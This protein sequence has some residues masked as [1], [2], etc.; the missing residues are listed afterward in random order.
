M[1]SRLLPIVIR[2][3]GPGASPVVQKKV[4]EILS[5]ANK[6]TRALPAL[7]LPLHELAELYAGEGGR[8]GCRGGRSGPF[9]VACGNGWALGRPAGV[10]R[11][12][13]PTPR[14]HSCSTLPPT[15]LSPAAPAAPETG[16][17]ARNFAVVY[18]EQAVARAPP[19][20]R[21]AE[22]RTPDCLPGLAGVER[23]H[24]MWRA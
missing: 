4:L 21:F 14:P 11:C 5:H 19:A 3:L 15:C 6:R 16:V 20:E 17:M 2:K 10:P 9:E 23:L 12:C 7:R 8:S 13:R 22:A 24:V 1:L 18:L